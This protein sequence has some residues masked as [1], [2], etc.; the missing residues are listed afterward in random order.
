MNAAFVHSKVVNQNSN[1][2]LVLLTL[3]QVEQKCVVY[4]ELVFWIFNDNEPHQ[5][6]R[7]VILDFRKLS[8]YS[9]L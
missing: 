7:S 4:F 9:T 2:I 6:V 3:G 5:D 8:E 1:A